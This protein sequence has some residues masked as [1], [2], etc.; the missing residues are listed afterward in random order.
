MVQ[1]P[2]LTDA[3]RQEKKEEATNITSQPDAEKNSAG[4]GRDFA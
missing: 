2:A 3:W 1:N 4:C